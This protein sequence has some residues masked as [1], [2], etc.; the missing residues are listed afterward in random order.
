MAPEQAQG[1]NRQ[2]TTAVDVYSLGA[3]LYELLTGE[4]PFKANTPLETIRQVLETELR[5][6]SLVNRAVDRDLE[7]ICLKCLE[8]D[9]ARRYQSAEALAEDLGRWQN[10]EPINARPATAADRLLKWVRRRPA[11][12]ALACVSL[13]SILVI[14][15]TVAVNQSRLTLERDATQARLAEALLREGEAYAANQRMAEAK[16]KVLESRNLS[17][18]KGLST[19]LPAATPHASWP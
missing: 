7:T 17:E 15:I 4:T 8:K 11:R 5:R 10:H 16:Q 13:L 1:K 18:M 6:P 3:I 9:P 2:L 14:F 12:A 19:L